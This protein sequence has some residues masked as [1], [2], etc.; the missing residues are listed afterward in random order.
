M[1]LFGDIEN[2]IGKVG[3]FFAP[4]KVDTS[5]VSNAQ[6]A[7]DFAAQQLE[8]ERQIKLATPAPAPQ[9]AGASIEPPT[10]VSLPPPPPAPP[11]APGMAQG[12]GT[13]SGKP[14]PQT[15][16]PTSA[17]PPPGGMVAMP[18]PNYID[19]V[20]QR[21]L[22]ALDLLTSA[23][24][25]DQPSAADLASKAA[26]DRAAAQQYGQAAALQGGMSA[27]GALRMASEG[28][29]SILGQNAA[30]RL[31]GHAKETADARNSLVQ[32]LGGLRTQENTLATDQAR[33]DLDA[34]INNAKL[35]LESRGLD[36]QMVH[37]LLM[38]RLQ[39]EG[40][41]VDMAKA[42]LDGNEKS[43]AAD[44][45]FKASLVQLPIQA[46]APFVK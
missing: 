2:G 4:K 3:T 5:P 46:V 33:M 20:R 23:A 28:S 30:D 42:I 25:G 29:A 6:S 10:M 41:S 24:K 15:P 12:F 43:A 7:A 39:E 44:N 21:Q 36:Q 31:A 37:D 9:V 19:P 17:A 8:T 32:G 22:D 40:Y 26:A 11:Q 16:P 34:Q 35:Q 45:A 14:F 18:P 1:G 38:A 13:G 27:G